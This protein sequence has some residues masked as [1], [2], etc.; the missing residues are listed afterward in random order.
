MNQMKGLR[1]QFIVEN[2]ALQSILPGTAQWGAT[3][4]SCQQARD[5]VGMLGALVRVGSVANAALWE[6]PQRGAGEGCFRG[7]YEVS[8]ALVGVS[9]PA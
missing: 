5:A 1:D 3:N 4:W 9:S 7:L 8:L 2:S 6:E